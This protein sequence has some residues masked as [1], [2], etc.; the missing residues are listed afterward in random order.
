[1]VTAKFLLRN[2]FLDMVS[3]ETLLEYIGYD[4]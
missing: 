2:Y 1:M 3:Y 4:L